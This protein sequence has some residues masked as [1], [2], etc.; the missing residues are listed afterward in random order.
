[1]KNSV[2]L[3]DHIPPKQ[4]LR[5]FIV[6]IFFDEI[7]RLRDHIPPKQGLR[8]R[9][10]IGFCLKI[11][12]LRDHIPPKQGLRLRNVFT[13]KFHWINTQRPYPTKTRIKTS[14]FGICFHLF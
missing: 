6:L 12:E 9:L 3:R 5:L 1:M 8:L 2:D 11:H 7:N 10:L 4:G 14:V 13:C